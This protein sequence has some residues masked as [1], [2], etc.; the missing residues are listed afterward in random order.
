VAAA[1]VA[2]AAVTEAVFNSPALGGLAGQATAAA[3]GARRMIRLAHAVA[4]VCRPL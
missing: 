3:V 4:Q 2:A 1:D